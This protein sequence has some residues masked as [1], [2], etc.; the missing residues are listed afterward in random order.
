MMSLSVDINYKLY[1]HG[2]LRLI[3]PFGLLLPWYDY[4]Y[5][6]TFEYN[7]IILSLFKI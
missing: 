6:L 1:S 5:N 3:N 2:E 7:Y 4:E